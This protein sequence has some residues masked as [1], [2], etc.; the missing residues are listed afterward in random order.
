MAVG[1]SVLGNTRFVRL[2]KERGAGELGE[3]AVR[4]ASSRPRP[5]GI[6]MRR[7]GRP[8]PGRQLARNDFFPFW[9][10]TRE[11]T[12]PGAIRCRAREWQPHGSYHAPGGL[13][14][15]CVELLHSAAD[16]AIAGVGIAEYLDVQQCDRHFH[17]GCDGSRGHD[18][19][20]R[21]QRRRRGWF[22]FASGFHGA[23]R[24]RRATDLHGTAFVAD[25]CHRSIQ[26]DCHLFWADASEPIHDRQPDRRPRA[27]HRC[28]AHDRLRRSLRGDPRSASPSRAGCSP[29]AGH[30]YYPSTTERT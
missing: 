7:F 22:H 6:P 29:G 23:P 2:G 8:M 1:M 25:A 20:Q 30:A 3:R 19:L 5:I 24:S 26:R 15:R 14:S 28:D 11:K 21:V 9:G 16:F 18:I 10:Q 17:A 12:A 13:H 4:L 27:V